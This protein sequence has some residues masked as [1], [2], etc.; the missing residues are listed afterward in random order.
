MA[1]SARNPCMPTAEWFRQRTKDTEIDLVA[2]CIGTV[3]SRQVAA[4]KWQC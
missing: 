2:G 1:T 3:I 4:I